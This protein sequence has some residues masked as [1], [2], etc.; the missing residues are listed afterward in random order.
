ME[1]TEYEM[2]WQGSA[3][4]MSAGLIKEKCR[5]AV[6]LLFAGIHRAIRRELFR[7]SDSEIYRETDKAK[8]F[9]GTSNFKNWVSKL[10]KERTILKLKSSEIEWTI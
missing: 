5:N 6:Q 3:D 2:F 10:E 9:L 4:R 8:L 1:R 7:S